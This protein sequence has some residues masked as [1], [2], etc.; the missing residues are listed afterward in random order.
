MDT[1]LDNTQLKR[2]W[3]TA[4]E[5]R[6]C[7]DGDTL[8]TEVPDEKLGRHLHLCHVCRD[9][10][11][12]PLEQRTAWLEL[13][14][15]FAVS[16]QQPAKPDKPMRGQVWSIKQSLAGWGEDGYFY[17]PPTVLL[18]E[19][20]EGS[21][22]FKAVQ[23]YGDRVLMGEGDTWLDHRF[24][25]AQGWNCYTIHEDALDGCWGAV[26][27]KSLDQVLNAV[28]MSH[29]PV[30]EDS[31]FYFFRRMELNVGARVAL[32]SVAVLVEEWNESLAVAA[33][34]SMLERFFGSLSA[35]YSKL[36]YINTPDFADS[37]MD[38]LTGARDPRGPLPVAAATS[39]QMPVNIVAKQ[40][41]GTISIKTIGAVVTDDD[42]QDDI[43]FVAGRLDEAP[44]EELYL[45]AS[46]NHKGQVISECQ[47]KINKGSPYFDIVFRGIPKEASRIENLKFLLVRS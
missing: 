32:P 11:D 35:A 42:W 30:E 26:S 28:V 4:F 2:A 22:G 34:E 13:M 33:N 46:L 1:T 6:L 18:L 9:K 10:R 25:F 17:K 43:Y 41:D 21:S 16:G 38:L 8:F 27:E 31:I 37:L 24:G 12:M 29:A 40:L 19:K 23:L 14:Q 15:R 5:L 39:A 47:N 36:K 3:Q 7:P 20:I 45:L 44:Q